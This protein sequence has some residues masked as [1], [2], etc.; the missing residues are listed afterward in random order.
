[1]TNPRFATAVAIGLA[2]AVAVV[3]PIAWLINTRD[4]GVGLMLLVP[5][6]VYGL[7]RLAR[8]LEAWARNG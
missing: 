7:I 2:I 1:M 6:I 8:V 4:W 3:L 5:F